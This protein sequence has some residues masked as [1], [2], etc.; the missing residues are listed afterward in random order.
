MALGGKDMRLLIVEDEKSINRVICEKCKDEG[1]LVDCCFDGESALSYLSATSY[2][3]IILDIMLPKI[4]GFTVLKTMRANK[5][6]TPVLFLSA[7]DQVED[8]VY[9]LD[10]GADDYLIKPFS[11]QELMARIRLLLRR[12]QDKSNVYCAQG[13]ILNYE[14]KEVFYHEKA[15]AL[16]SKE[17]YVLEYLL[18]NKGI[19]VSRE[20]I[21][22]HIWGFDFDV[23]SNMVDVY[24]SYLRKKLDENEE[25]K[26]IETIRGMGYVIR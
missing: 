13:I 26:V 5:D 3:V 12:K 19:V 20:Q 4:D 6:N 24:I 1:Y 21:G 7:R 8:R 9:G 10:I 16:S 22:N 15:I 11:L 2:D 14:S 17:Y 18:K 25:R 23:S